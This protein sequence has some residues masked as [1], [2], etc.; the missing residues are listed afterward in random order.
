MARIVF[1]K[2]W[3]ERIQLQGNKLQAAGAVREGTVRDRILLAASACFAERGIRPVS[4]VHICDAVGMSPS[5]IR[6]HFE[7]K[8]D[9]VLALLER[10][11]GMGLG[12]LPDL[13]PETVAAFVCERL[14]SW[15]ATGASN[16]AFV[17]EAVAEGTRRARVAGATAEALALERHALVALLQARMR[18]ACKA[19][20]EAEVRGRVFALQCFVEG[21]VLRVAR[22]PDMDLDIVG[23]SV[24]R[25]V[26]QAVPSF[27]PETPALGVC[28]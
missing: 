10:L 20:P 13:R 23:E 3:A 1:T 25:F 28:A 21:V 2:K 19:L 26:A 17:L 14:R 5:E 9:I 27:E 7:T 8:D 16:A 22:E 4:M 15:R 24:R 12:D 6:L 11:Q 18:Q